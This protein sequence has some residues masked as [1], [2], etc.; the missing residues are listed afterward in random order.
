MKNL[1]IK[2]KLLSTAGVAMLII[3]TLAGMNIWSTRQATN[4]LASVYENEVMPMSD[5]T[6]IDAALKE[7]RFRMA[8]VVIDQMPFVGSKNHLGEVRDAIPKAWASF[9]KK[10][11]DKAFS[12]EETELIQKVDKKIKDLPGFFA[13][14]DAAY[15]GSDKTGVSKL[16]ED[17]WP[18]IHGGLI[19][20]LGQLLP[21]QQASV[22]NTYDNSVAASKRSLTTSSIVALVSLIVILGFTFQVTTS[23]HKS[24]SALQTALARVAKGDLSVRADVKNKDELGQM[25]E[26][27][28]QTIGQLRDTVNGVKDAANAVAGSATELLDEANEVL[29]RAQTQTDGVMQ[30]SAAMEESAVSV[31]EVAHNAESVEQ[32]AAKTQ[33]MAHEGN[34]LMGKSAEATRRIVDAVNSSSTT[35]SGLS[36]SIDKVGEITRVIKEIAEQTN[37]LALNAAIEAAR[38]GEQGRGFAVVADEVRKLAERTATSTTDITN[39]IQPIKGAT[40]AVVGAI[41][42]IHQEVSAGNEYNRSAEESLSKIVASAED[43]SSMA[44]QITGA[45]KEQSVAS[46]EVA[47]NMEKI[48]VLTEDNSHSIQNVDGAAKRLAR[49]AGE[50]QRLIGA[51]KT[52]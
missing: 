9:Q 23:I 22:K 21:L 41:T 35:I 31:N 28:N 44:R 48:S 50:L 12:A 38:A 49:T 24:I 32:A 10:T 14:L 39:M 34:T 47:R 11:K 26:S 46:E 42:K 1:S 43:V 2:A 29:Q 20:P 36:Q 6:A 16:L 4:A 19:K 13:K 37:L 5:L 25:A 7:V 27:L 8:G 51:F 18:L 17:D 33:S 45:V 30:V 15:A 40:D 52:A 3:L